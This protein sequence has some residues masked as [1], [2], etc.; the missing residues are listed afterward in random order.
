VWKFDGTTWTEV[1]AN[2][3]FSG[4]K[5]HAAFEFTDFGSV[6]KMAV[7]GGND[8]T[9]DLSDLWVS[10]DGVIWTE[11]TTGTT[12]AACGD[13]QVWQ[14]TSLQPPLTLFKNGTNVT[15]FN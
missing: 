7:Y 13:C 9:N 2:A 4:R 12:N 3:G 6:T 15:Q 5:N 8:G 11:V 10:E 14:L 1:T